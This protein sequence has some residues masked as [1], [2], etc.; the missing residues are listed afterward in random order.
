MTRSLVGKRAAILAVALLTSSTAFSSECAPPPQLQATLRAH[1]TAENYAA[2]GEY[3]GNK[4]EHPCA[5]QAFASA[6]KLE[7]RSAKFSYL[8]GLN[9]YAAGQA[10]PAAD[11][12]Q[13]SIQLNPASLQAHLLL[14]TVLD[15]LHRGPEAEAQWRAALA[16][17]PSSALALDGLAKSLLASHQYAAV[18]QLLR[19]AARDENLALDLAIAYDHTG[20]LDEATATLS[21]ALAAAPSSLPL[22]NALALA[23]IKQDRHQDAASLLEKQYALHP[24]DTRNAARLLPRAGRE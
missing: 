15:Q 23:Y 16:I 17:D 22:A 20:K 1:P 2:L 4:D 7:P 12:L 18:V 13:Q 5:A 14:A 21:Q 3:F 6:L 11:A 24:D 9:L 19:P 10:E 8:L